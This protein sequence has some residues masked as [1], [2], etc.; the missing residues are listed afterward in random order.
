MYVERCK[1][2]TTQHVVI[3]RIW[4]VGGVQCKEKL[5]SFF[6]VE[7]LSESGLPLPAP[8]HFCYI[9]F[10]CARDSI[11]IPLL[12]ILYSLYFMVQQNVFVCISSITFALTRFPLQE[13]LRPLDDM[14]TELC[15]WAPYHGSVQCS[16]HVLPPASMVW[17][18]S[19]SRVDIYFAKILYGFDCI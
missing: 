13:Q 6:L 7:V 8:H 1:R 10:I 9:Y 18:E 15:G 17:L 19:I 4:C 5:N 12:G 14:A 2:N 16:V 3:H 11:F